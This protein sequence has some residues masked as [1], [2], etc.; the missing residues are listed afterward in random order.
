MEDS[1]ANKNDN[2]GEEEGRWSLKG[3]TALVT[4]G[5]KGIGYATVEELAGLGAKVYTCSRN[6]KELQECLAIWRNKGFKVEGYVCD[7]LLRTER[8][9]LMRAVGDVFNGKLNILVNNAGV[10]IHKESKDFTAEDH[11]IV[12]GTNFDAGFHLSQLAYPLLK[13]S[14][15]GNV[16]FLSSIAGFSALPSVSLYCASKGAINQMTKSLACEWAKDNIRVNAVAP[17]VIMTPLIETA[18][19]RQQLTQARILLIRAHRLIFL[20]EPRTCSRGQRFY[21]LL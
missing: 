14:E 1:N 10:V 15:N 3:K 12:M 11:N 9:N 4:G 19:K 21:L 6:E 8:E 5:S 18:I 2:N 7:L 16:I 13:A 17:G 20:D